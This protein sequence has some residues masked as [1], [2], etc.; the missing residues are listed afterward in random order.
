MKLTMWFCWRASL[1]CK[2][3]ISKINVWAETVVQPSLLLISLSLSL[4]LSLSTLV[5]PFRPCPRELWLAQTREANCWEE[6]ADW[7]KEGG[8]AQP[9]LSGHHHYKYDNFYMPAN[10]AHSLNPSLV[11]DNEHPASGLCIVP[12]P[13]QTMKCTLFISR[14]KW[15][16]C[17][18]LH[19]LLFT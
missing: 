11:S 1:V 15:F 6:E 12:R 19:T 17:M 5:L 16:S 3:S 18:A 8:T 10:F 2:S 14:N 13:L 9:T 7:L 4:S